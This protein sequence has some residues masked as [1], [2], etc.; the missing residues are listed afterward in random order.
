MENHRSEHADRV[1]QGEHRR[2]SKLDLLH[3][4]GDLMRIT[5]V[6]LLKTGDQMI[7]KDETAN[8]NDVCVLYV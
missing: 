8:A 5:K 4:S 6:R 2:G 3:P 7:I 1:L